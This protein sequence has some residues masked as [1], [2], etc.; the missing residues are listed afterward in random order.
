MRRDER[1]RGN[2]GFDW[3]TGIEFPVPIPKMTRY[4]RV[5]R[6]SSGETLCR[7]IR[8]GSLARERSFESAFPTRSFTNSSLRSSIFVLVLVVVISN[9]I[10]DGFFEKIS[11]N[12][13]RWL[14]RKQTQHS[15]NTLGC[16][17]KEKL[18]FEISIVEKRRG[19]LRGVN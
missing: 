7:E 16:M 2:L 14:R 8:Q 5:P 17:G 18:A 11:L 1:F 3:T 6:A 9:R 13:S 12:D 19:Y 4:T 10:E 15:C